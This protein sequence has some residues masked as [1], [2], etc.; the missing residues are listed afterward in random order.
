MPKPDA[1]ADH[2]CELIAE[3]TRHRR[4]SGPHWIAVSTV[5][6]ELRRHGVDIAESDL[7]AAISLCVGRHEMKAEGKPV[8]SVS[9]WQ[10]D[11]DLS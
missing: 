7:Q 3:L 9:P 6:R 5:A 2:L 4:G 11:W 8:H 10:K 1:L